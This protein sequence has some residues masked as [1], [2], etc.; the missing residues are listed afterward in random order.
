MSLQA[1]D[2]LS[3]LY[4]EFV[5]GDA[6]V[7]KYEARIM[8]FARTYEACKRL[9]KIPG[10]GPLTATAIVA[11]VGNAIHFKNGRALAASLGLTPKEHSSGG[12]QKLLGVSKRGNGYIRRLLIQGHAS[13]RATLCCDQTRNLPASFG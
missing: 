11:H 3:E 12:K 7:A 8:T 6:A 5:D 1:R 9:Q 4:T 10:V 13:S 2:Y